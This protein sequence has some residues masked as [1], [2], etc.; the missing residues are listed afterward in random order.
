MQRLLHDIYRARLTLIHSQILLPWPLAAI[1]FEASSLEPG[2]YPIEVGIALWRAPDAPIL[3]W[4]ALVRP[5]EEW[6]RHGHWSPD[7]AQV[8]GIRGSE[9]RA[10]GQA[11]ARLAA[12]LNAVLGS[13]GEAWCDGGPYDAYWMRALFKAGGMKPDSAL[14]D[15]HRLAAGLGADRAACALKWLEEAPARHRARA[16]AE[17]LLFALAHAVGADPG[18]AQ[19]F[20]AASFLPA[21]G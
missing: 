15:W 18:P 14:R 12:L 19:D 4:S 3:G 10:Q 13:G 6:M 2:G 21:A 5:T 9:L 17:K 20:D 7:S 11:P 16:D 1:D 8:H